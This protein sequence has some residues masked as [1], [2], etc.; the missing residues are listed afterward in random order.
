MAGREQPE[1]AAEAGC[2]S[3]AAAEPVAGGW[4]VLV[5]VWSSH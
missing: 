1:S 3:V 4:S 5:W 2:R